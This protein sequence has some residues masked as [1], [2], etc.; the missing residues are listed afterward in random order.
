MAAPVLYD[1]FFSDAEVMALWRQAA[2]L[3]IEGTGHDELMT[4]PPSLA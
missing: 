1:Q 3:V 4:Q 2:A